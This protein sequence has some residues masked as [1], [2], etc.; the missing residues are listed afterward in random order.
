MERV[1]NN[2]NLQ[3]RNIASNLS[4]TLSMD[5]FSWVH[6]PPN[7]IFLATFHVIEN[8]DMC[9]CF[10]CRP[11]FTKPHAWCSISYACNFFLFSPS[12]VILFETHLT[13][14][15]E[16]F[17]SA[18]KHRFTILWEISPF[19]MFNILIKLLILIYFKYKNYTKKDT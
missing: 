1:C 8:V 10:Q 17:Q 11:K 16:H 5:S 14:N 19:V 9:P 6:R 7:S 12:K 2:K 18:F 13:I 3:E 15:Y 4:W